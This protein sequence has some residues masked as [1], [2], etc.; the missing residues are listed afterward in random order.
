MRA[1][2]LLDGTGVDRP[3]LSF[4][5][6]PD[7]RELINSA[8]DASK[9]NSVVTL[10][11]GAGASIDSDM[12]TWRELIQRL[13][14]KISNQDL[15]R[16]LIAEDV[17]LPRR[18]ELILAAFTSGS[19]E[20]V[21]I[22]EALYRDSGR[23][24]PG[25]LA[26]SIAQIAKS[27]APNVNI[28]TTNYDDRLELALARVAADGEKV[29]SFGLN[30]IAEWKASKSKYKVL[31]LHGY[32]PSNQLAGV[33]PIEPIVLSESSYVYVGR[34]VQDFVEE[35]LESSTVLFIGTSMTDPSVVRPLHRTVQDGKRSGPR[36]FAL[37][38]PKDDWA[39]D[40]SAIAA[41]RGF[42]KLQLRYLRQP[43]NIGPI[44]LKSYGQMA[45]CIAEVVT[46]IRHP[47]AYLSDD[48]DTSLRYGFRF[49]RT[50][51]AVGV[52]LDID[53]GEF[54]PS[55]DSSRRSQRRPC[56]AAYDWWQNRRVSKEVRDGLSA[57]P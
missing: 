25:P 36:P 37:W 28:V 13:A 40:E 8:I 21:A 3:S 27:L 19:P 55:G 34:Q 10:F 30:S 42:T 2:E 50:M 29:E 35:C 49:H 6:Q 7:F 57:F 45:Q 41:R 20:S 15:A 31:H 54:A 9:Q 17:D 4:A 46:A 33:P 43:L 47:D 53:S 24:A 5:R 23:Q 44:V 32:L 11:C 48:P 12:P 14:E 26:A 39:G 56:G 52:K 16:L 38:V 51:Q 18:V 1:L 22:S